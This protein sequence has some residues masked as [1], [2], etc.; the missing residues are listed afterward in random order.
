MQLLET[1]KKLSMEKLQSHKERL[2]HTLGVV[3]MASY[4]AK[5]YGVDETKVQIAAYMHDFCKYDDIS[6]AKDIL[7]S[8]DLAECEKYPFL[9][10]A[11]MAAEYFKKYLSDDDE[12]YLAIRN[13]VFGR[14]DMTK[15][16]EILMISDYTEEN[17]KYKECIY[18][19]ELIYEGKINE[20]IYKSLEATINHCINNNEKPHP[21]QIAVCKQ[22][23]ERI[24]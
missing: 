9:Y 2:E 16:E 20:A 3:K 21:V 23:K 22:I 24:K 19:R 8:E 13:H 14:V 15:I 5:I 6:L 4:L 10:H 7:N 18:C 17:R 11:Y 1:C 12:I